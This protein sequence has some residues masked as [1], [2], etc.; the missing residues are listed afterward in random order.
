MPQILVRFTLRLAISE[1][2][3]QG[4]RKSEMH[5]MTQT[6]KHSI[7]TTYL[8]L[9]PK[10]WSVSLYDYPFLRYKVVKIGNAPSEANPKLNT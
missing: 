1:I 3:V 9:R 10:F 4:G 7:D 5:Q 8:P 6:E 2:Y